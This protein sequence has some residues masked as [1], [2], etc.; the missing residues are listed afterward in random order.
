MILAR[1][2][3]VRCV[4]LGETFLFFPPRRELS[5]AYLLAKFGVDTAENEPRALY[6]L[7]AAWRKDAT[8]AQNEPGARAP[9]VARPGGTRRPAPGGGGRPAWIGSIWGE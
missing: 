4:D 7:K 9:G 1:C 6:F 3:G 5:N 8:R 2:K